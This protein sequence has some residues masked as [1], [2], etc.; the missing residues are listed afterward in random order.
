MYL[1][2]GVNLHKL[3]YSKYEI[4]FYSTFVKLRN[5]Y[6][7]LTSIKKKFTTRLSNYKFHDLALQDFSITSE[8]NSGFFAFRE[9][10]SG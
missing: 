10:F 6:S 5:S 7:F 3:C 9:I 1:F 2:K 4:T 8:Q